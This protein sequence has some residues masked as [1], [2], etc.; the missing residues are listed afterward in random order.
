MFYVIDLMFFKLLDGDI[1][2]DIVGMEGRFIVIV[3]VNL[4]K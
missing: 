4:S 1:C 3:Y 2:R